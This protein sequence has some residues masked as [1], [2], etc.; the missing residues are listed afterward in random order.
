[1]AWPGADQ[2]ASHLTWRIG[3]T[4]H[5]IDQRQLKPALVPA[6]Q[7]ELITNHLGVWHM[8]AYRFL[9]SQ[10][11]SDEDGSRSSPTQLLVEA[12]AHLRPAPNARPWNYGWS[13][14]EYRHNGDPA[15]STPSGVMAMSPQGI[16]PYEQAVAVLMKMPA[17]VARWDAGQFWGTVAEVVAYIAQSTDRDATAASF[18]ERL[19]KS[20]PT[21]VAFPIANIT[22]Q[23]QPMKVSSGVIGYLNDEY[24]SAV[25]AVA[26]N[27]SKLEGG[28]LDKWKKEQAFHQHGSDGTV[29]AKKSKGHTESPAGACGSVAGS[30]IMPPEPI[31]WS[32][33]VPG[34]QDLAFKQAEREF[35]T[36]VSLTLLLE[37]DLGAHG[38]YMLRDNTNRPGI[39]GIALDR[40]AIEHLLGQHGNTELVTSVLM[41]SNATSGVSH[42]WLSADPVPLSDLLNNSSLKYDVDKCLSKDS[43]VVKRI[44]VAARWYFQAIWAT[45]IDDSA[46]ALGIALDALVGSRSG[47]PGR[48]LRQRFAFL[49]PDPTLR[50]GR[51][52]RFD[53]IYS[54]RSSVA[55]GGSSK[56][57]TF[58]FVKA[59]AADITWAAHRL[60]KLDEDFSPG[61]DSAIDEIYEGLRWDTLRWP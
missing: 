54:V 44:K 5:R 23:G 18:F 52:A 40:G 41:L 48:E 53:E 31:I 57:L 43:P 55:H 4:P 10:V 26:G 2:A 19:T 33:W 38:I 8:S 28:S 59:M 30:G 15:V 21:L 58:D 60:L 22:W 46:L 13:Q 27:R 9:V 24:V 29:K 50:A 56:R 39:R 3:G 42:R 34:Q 37:H 14:E 32:C 61:S 11:Q 7:P 49:E 51:A 25:N 12:A 20:S 36:V 47:L 35:E 6:S 45:Q 1:M 17:I 16:R